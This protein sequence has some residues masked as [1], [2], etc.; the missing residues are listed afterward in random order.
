MLKIGKL[1]LWAKPNRIQIK[2]AIILAIDHRAHRL[3]DRVN[4]LKM[5][6][7]LKNL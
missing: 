7:N 5:F 6:I 3:F 1:L 4:Y 2:N